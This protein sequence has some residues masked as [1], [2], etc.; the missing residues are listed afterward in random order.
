MKTRN[1]ITFPTAWP[2]LAG[3]AI[4]ALSVLGA[5]SSSATS[6]GD[7][8]AL[9]PPSNGAISPQNQADA[10]HLVIATD[11]ELY[12]RAYAARQS[13]DVP[14]PNASADGKPVES[15]PMPCEMMRRAA[16]STQSNGAEF[17]YALRSIRPLDPRNGPQTELEQRGLAFVAS[18]PGRNY[19]DQEML[20]GRRYVTAVY[21]DLPATA[22]CIDCHNRRSASVAPRYQVGEVMGGIVVRVPL[23]F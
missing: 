8:P 15:W 3:L 11:R 23:E 19:Y 7:V 21:P 17:S 4:L 5:G 13:G 14:A 6:P 22:S 1:R 2:L 20:G 9:P 12:C 10:L 18:H 16:D